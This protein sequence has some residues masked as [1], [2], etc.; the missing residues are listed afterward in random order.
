M[1]T[2]F[3]TG[4]DTNVGKS[5][6]ASLLL[7]QLRDDDVRVGT[8]KP[9]CSGADIV[10]DGAHRWPDVATLADDIHWT[11]DQDCVCPQRFVAPVVPNV[12]ARLEHRHVDDQLLRT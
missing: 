3:V 1:Q 12:A 8:Y 2:L 7:R 10:D 5:W 6:V 4:T 11:G 9:V